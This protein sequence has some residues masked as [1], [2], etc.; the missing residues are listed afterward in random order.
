MIQFLRGINAIIDGQTISD[1]QPA[2]DISNNVL[3]IGNGTSTFGGLPYLKGMGLYKQLRS[4]SSIGGWTSGSQSIPN[5]RNYNLFIVRVSSSIAC[6]GTWWGPTNLQFYG[7]STS[8]DYLTCCA[9]NI[10]FDDS[11][12]VTGNYNTC[13]QVNVQQGTSTYNLP[14]T[15]IFGLA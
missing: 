2:Y 14:I 7:I 11:T 12:T 3:K 13:T 5:V 8:S 9:G 4:F 6:M 15:S 10:L 1:G